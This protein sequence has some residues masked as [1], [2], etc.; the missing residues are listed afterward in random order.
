MVKVTKLEVNALCKLK[1]QP[2]TCYERFVCDGLFYLAD[3]L[4]LA[5]HVCPLMAVPSIVARSVFHVLSILTFWIRFWL[6][7]LLIFEKLTS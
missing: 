5:R 3:K 4:T 2:S 6:Q 1:A 7:H